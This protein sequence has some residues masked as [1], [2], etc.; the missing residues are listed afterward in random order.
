MLP[1]HIYAAPCRYSDLE[2]KAASQAIRYPPD[3]SY[4]YPFL[5]RSGML[6]CFQDLSFPTGAFRD[7]IDEGKIERHDAIDWWNVPE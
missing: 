2:T 1:Q 7:L 5:I 6:F 3:S 4:M